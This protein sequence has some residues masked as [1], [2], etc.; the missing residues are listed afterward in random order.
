MRWSS[1]TIVSSVTA[2]VAVSLLATGCGGGSAS[3][4]V[5]SLASPTTTGTTT[6]ATTTNESGS[7]QGDKS[8]GPGGPSG[9]DFRMVMNVGNAADGAKFSSCMRKHGVTN[10]PDPN[11]QGQISISSGMGIDPGSPTFR[12]AQTAC[13]KLLPN[14]GQATPEQRAEMQREML[15]YAQCMRAHGITDFPDP[16]NNGIQLKVGPGSDLNPANPQFQRAQTACQDKL[17]GKLGGAFKAKGGSA[18][19]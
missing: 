8:I 9:G 13:R 3:P 19:G 7:G 17:P 16:T 2:I 15:A 5:A 10:F 14:G 6:S 1:P 11:G 18:G 4:G 12:S